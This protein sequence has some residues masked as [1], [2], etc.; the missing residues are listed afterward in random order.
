MTSRQHTA[1]VQED[2]AAPEHA[3]EEAEV[4][5]AFVTLASDSTAGVCAADGVCS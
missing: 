3:P 4:R 1:S 5:P 2:D